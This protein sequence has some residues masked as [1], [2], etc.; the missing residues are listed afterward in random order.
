MSSVCPTPH[1][2][3][4][5]VSMLAQFQKTSRIRYLFTQGRRP[6]VGI[7]LLVPCGLRAPQ[8]T[9]AHHVTNVCGH[10]VWTTPHMVP[11]GPVYEADSVEVPGM[12][13]PQ[14]GC[15]LVRTNPDFSACRIHWQLFGSS[16]PNTVA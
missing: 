3:D 16:C 15:L 8:G 5:R 4:N 14:T 2:N 10:P 12:S 1:L 6:A 9:P 7:S 13:L 11:R